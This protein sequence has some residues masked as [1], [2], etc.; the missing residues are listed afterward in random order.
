MPELFTPEKVFGKSKYLK[1]FNLVETRLLSH[2]DPN[3][4]RRELNDRV[5]YGVFDDFDELIGQVVLIVS[6]NKG[7]RLS[8]SVGYKESCVMDDTP[9]LDVKLMSINIGIDNALHTL[10][11]LTLITDPLIHYQNSMKLS[12]AY[13]I[14]K[15]EVQE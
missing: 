8:T 4:N 10:T 6:D 15:K 12:N 2:L 13:E 7:K 9:D 3:G 14:A 1:Y 5:Y 11:F